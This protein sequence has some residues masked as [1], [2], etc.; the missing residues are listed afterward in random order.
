MGRYAL[1]WSDVR[2]PPG[3]DPA[4]DRPS[5]RVATTRKV[6]VRDIFHLPPLRALASIRLSVVLLVIFAVAIAKATF[7]ESQYGATGAR[8]LVYNARWFEV[9]LALLILNLVLVL[10]ARAPYKPR[11]YGSVIVH[12]AIIWILVAAGVTRYFGYEGVMPIREGQAA[13]FMYSREPHVQL[14]IDGRTGSFPVRLYRPGPDGSSGGLDFAGRDYRVTVEEYWPHFAETLQAAD[15]GPA[16][17]HLTMIGASNPED[18]FLVAGERRTYGGLRMGYAD[19]PLETATAGA[20]WGRLRVRADGETADFE[21]PD[22]LPADF[23]AGDWRFTVTEFQADFRVGRGTDYTGDLANPMV[24]VAVTAPDGREGEKILFAFH[25]EFSMGHGGGEE[26]FPDLDVLYQLSRGLDFGRDAAGALVARASSPL[27]AMG[28]AEGAEALDLAAGE[29]FTVEPATIY[30]SEADDLSFMLREELPHVRLR[31]ALSTDERAPAAVRLSVADGDGERAEAIV[32]EDDDRG[33]TVDLGGIDATLRFGAIVI[34]LPYSIHLDDFRMLTY[35]GSRNPAS[36]E[37]H[38]RL[39]DEAQGE[40]GRPV[41]IYMNHPLTHRGFKHFQSSYDPDE[42]G[43]VLS[44]NYDPG[45]IPTYLGYGLL[46]LG[47]LMILA[48]D[49]IWPSRRE[50]GERSAA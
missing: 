13:D 16:A 17:L 34:D 39:Y 1:S 48:R 24:R 49:L 26:A 11:Q 4:D 42:L 45:K 28:M 37:S 7:L 50:T 19:E 23:S 43:T 22:A 25:P 3:S 2:P 10:F 32:I 44:V 5:R 46:T 8:D 30:R 18:L 31:P 9:V 29:P 12:V 35:P 36:Y 38:V 33:E 6:N 21:V 47:F 14:E 27:A 20:R 41:R 15:S 40:D